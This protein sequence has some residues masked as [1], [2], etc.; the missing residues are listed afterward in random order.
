LNVAG[1]LRIT[2]PAADVAAAAALVSSLLATPLPAED[3]YFG[4]IS[5][6]GAVRPVS[7]MTTR[8]REAHKLGFKSAVIPASGDDA[9]VAGRP[10]QQRLRHVRESIDIG[11]GG[12]TRSGNAPS[13]RARGED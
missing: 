1:G 11:G 5:L 6:S 13:S 10:K 12:K 4:E 8:L 7:H 3:V 9:N 2:E